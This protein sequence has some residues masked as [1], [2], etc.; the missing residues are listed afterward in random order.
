MSYVACEDALLVLLGG[1]TGL[2]SAQV[3]RADGSLLGEGH[4]Q[5]IVT[6]YGGF[7]QEDVAGGGCKRQTWGVECELHVKWTDDAQVQRDLTTLRQG[8]IDRVGQYPELNNTAYWADV[9]NGEPLPED[10]EVG[11]VKYQRERLRVEVQEQVEYT[12]AE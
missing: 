3:G 2:S 8:I 5:F 9:V 6:R 7:T 11:S 4:E 1:V 12:Y 10:V